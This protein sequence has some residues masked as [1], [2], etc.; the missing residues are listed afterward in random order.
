MTKTVIETAKFDNAAELL[1]WLED[2]NPEDLNVMGFLDGH[3]QVVRVESTLTDGS[4]V[5]DLKFQT[6]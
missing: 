1:L 6:V 3:L 2:Q 5:Q 4:K